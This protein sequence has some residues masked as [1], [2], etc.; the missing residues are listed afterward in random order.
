MKIIPSD[1][2]FR[3][4]IAIPPTEGD[5]LFF[6]ER[7]LAIALR[8]GFPLYTND[9]IRS[10]SLSLWTLNQRS[11][12]LYALNRAT[13]CIWLPVGVLESLQRELAIKL[14]AIQGRLEVPTMLPTSKLSLFARKSCLDVG[15]YQ[16]VSSK[17]W[18]HSIHGQKIE[19]LQ[20]WF[21]HNKIENYAS[22]ELRRLPAS[23]RNE[24][25]RVKLDSALNTYL[26]SSGPNC[27]GAV[28][29]AISGGGRAAARQWLHW[30]PLERF[31]RDQH[32][33][34][35]KTSTPIATDVLIFKCKAEAIHAAYLIGDG[36][37]FEMP[38]QDFYELYRV[39]KFENWRQAWPGSTLSIFRKTV[40]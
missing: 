21:K 33:K 2:D 29:S 36:Y 31:L 39:E 15:R 25:K 23:A 22:I 18:S 19:L 4:W 6:Q 1:A 35:V 16:W 5:L 10:Q 20:V 11:W 37:Y 17:T 7:D 34:V 8:L 12:Y 9:E 32:Y 38:G 40:F 13:H 26:N 14:S 24:L 30:Q 3:K 27:F 28:A